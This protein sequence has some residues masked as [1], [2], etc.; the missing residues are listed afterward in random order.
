MDEEK[1]EWI[2]KAISQVQGASFF[3]FFADT[4][5]LVIGITLAASNNVGESSESLGMFTA[6]VIMPLWAMYL[7]S[8]PTRLQPFKLYEF[9]YPYLKGRAPK[10]L[11]WIFA[12]FVPI[13]F[14]VRLV[15]SI[16]M[17]IKWLIRYII[18]EAFKPVL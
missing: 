3:W 11:F 14:L 9:M 4:V 12:L 16:I 1:Q 17:G 5:L 6:V 10:I 7:I 2:D 13:M 8:I 15:I 18:T